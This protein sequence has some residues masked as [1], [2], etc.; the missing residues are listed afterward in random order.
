MRGWTVTDISQ[1]KEESRQHGVK[2]PT[3]SSSGYEMRS[4]SV[5]MRSSV[6]QWKPIR[7]R[8]A[9]GQI[10]SLDGKQHGWQG[11]RCALTGV[12]PRSRR[13]RKAACVNGCSCDKSEGCTVHELP[14]IDLECYDWARSG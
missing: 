5:P 12:S 1:K 4:M 7:M 8:Q 9:E 6:Q 3:S 2:R 14:H 11:G 10:A 13:G